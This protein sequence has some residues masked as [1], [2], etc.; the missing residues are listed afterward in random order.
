M[1]Y[2]I[3][4]TGFY[5]SKLILELIILIIHLLLFNL[6]LMRLHCS[7][8][9]Y[10]SKKRILLVHQPLNGNRATCV[11]VNFSCT[12]YSVKLEF[13]IPFREGSLYT[14]LRSKFRDLT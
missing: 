10:K 4:R 9:S 12:L 11:L 3:G 7:L 1:E 5:C 2:M 8:I 14:V 6:S 13:C